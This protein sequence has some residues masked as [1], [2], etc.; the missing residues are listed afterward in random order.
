MVE[1][2]GM[3][4]PTQAELRQRAAA[5]VEETMA[6]PEETRARLLDIKR[7]AIEQLVA[8]FDRNAELIASHYP[9]YT[10]EDLVALAGFLPRGKSDS[11]HL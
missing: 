5:I 11:W 10:K 6:Y 7:G 2:S 4:R 9:E 3:A 1:C 8:A